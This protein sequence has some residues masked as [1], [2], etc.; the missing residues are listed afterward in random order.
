[1]HW[2]LWLRTRYV[3]AQE[4]LRRSFCQRPAQVNAGSGD[5]EVF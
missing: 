4:Y 5:I 1:M 3:L 2:S